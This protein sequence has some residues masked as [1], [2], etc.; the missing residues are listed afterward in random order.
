MA[1][2]SQTWV[3]NLIGKTLKQAK[4]DGLLGGGENYSTDE[5]RIGTWIDGKP[6]YR[7]VFPVDISVSTSW[8]DTGIVIN[9]IKAIINYSTLSSSASGTKN[10]NLATN[11][12]PTA[13]NGINM[14]SYGGNYQ[15]KYIVI[16]YTKT[17]D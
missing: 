11:I 1:Y 10:G 14:V 12:A 7:R 13:T 8:A 6:I 16:E 4:D 5:I 2:A 9:N 3:K 15:V 17:T